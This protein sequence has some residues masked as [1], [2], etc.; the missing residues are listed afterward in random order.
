MLERMER[1]ADM[2]F[3]DSTKPEVIV[4]SKRAALR[5]CMP[6]CQAGPSM[7]IHAIYIYIYIKQI[8]IG[9]HTLKRT[10]SKT[11]YAGH[12]ASPVKNSLPIVE[13][14]GCKLPE[15]QAYMPTIAH[16]SAG[17]KQ[18]ARHLHPRKARKKLA[19]V[20][21]VACCSRLHV[22]PCF[23]VRARLPKC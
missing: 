10:L 18:D 22:R 2:Y 12:Q 20:T 19:N 17:M 15:A 16:C 1:E 23:G 9:Q 6:K 14:A 4:I 8:H 13:A 21:C 3:R 7:L 5:C 11:N